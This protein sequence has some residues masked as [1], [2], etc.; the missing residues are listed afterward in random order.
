[1]TSY[2]KNL[3]IPVSSVTLIVLVTIGTIT[4]VTAQNITLN[5]DRL[6]SLEEPLAIEAGDVT[7][8][9]TG[10]VDTPLS[11]GL[12]GNGTTDEGF[13]GNFEVSANT[14]LPNRWRL[15]LAYFGQ[16]ADDPE[17]T[18]DMNDHFR[19]NV[20]LSVGGT[21]GTVLGGNLSGLVRE[22]TRR[23][24]GAGNAFLAFDDVFGRLEHWGGG[25]RGRFGPWIISTV[26]DEDVNVDLGAMFQ[27]PLGNRDYRFSARYTE[28]VYTSADGT[29]RF[30]TRALGV[31]GELVYG[32]TLL[33]IGAG[34]ECFTASGPDAG[35]WYV[36]SG[37][38]SKHGV[39]T[40]SVEGHYGQIEGKD[41]TAAAMGFQYDMARGL[42]AN[43]GLNHENARAN[44]DHI[45]FIDTKDTKAVFSLRYSF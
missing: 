45:N 3:L 36:S 25:Y 41:K 7:F 15:V 38:R 21:W 17:L 43:I 28:G 42:S 23:P 30:N 39:L 5:Y 31:V 16:F 10:L 12:E 34:Y 33:D 8:L 6:S 14:Q 18:V 22:Q 4:P 27:R 35:Q 32:S 9:L 1:M 37:V 40:W 13:I 2:K 24:R 20:A 29:G 11:V 44:I 26:V 19:D